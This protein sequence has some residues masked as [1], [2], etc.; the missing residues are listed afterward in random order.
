MLCLNT[1]YYLN[2]LSEFFIEYTKFLIETLNVTMTYNDSII[3][4]IFFLAII[5]SLGMLKIS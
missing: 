5:V 4:M 2:F 3:V 1:Y